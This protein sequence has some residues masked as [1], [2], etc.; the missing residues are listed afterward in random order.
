MTTEAFE[1][2]DG[3]FKDTN[4]VYL[5]NYPYVKNFSKIKG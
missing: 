3:N 1:K 2:S 5:D 4:G